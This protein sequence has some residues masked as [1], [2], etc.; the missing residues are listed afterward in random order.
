MSA[1][2]TAILM[3]TR[4]VKRCHNLMM[5]VC[6]PSTQRCSM[7]EAEKVAMILTMLEGVEAIVHAKDGGW[8]AMT[9]LKRLRLNTEAQQNK[10]P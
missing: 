2:A 3:Q 10:A 9:I 4:L 8:G 7:S 1:A 6:V 5:L